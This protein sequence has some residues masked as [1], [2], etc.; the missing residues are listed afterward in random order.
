LLGEYDP[1]YKEEETYQKW[2][3]KK[4]LGVKRAKAAE[5]AEDGGDKK[6][7]KGKKGKK[8]KKIK[9]INKF[10]FYKKKLLFY[11]YLITFIHK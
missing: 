2:L 11:L 1:I 8:G 9:I 4:P 10:C 7:R 3:K 5:E 6:V